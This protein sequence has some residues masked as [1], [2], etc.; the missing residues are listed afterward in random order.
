MQI[1]TKDGWKEFQKLGKV[2]TKCATNTHKR[3]RRK[4]PDMIVMT[5]EGTFHVR[6]A[7]RHAWFTTL[8]EARACL[9]RWEAE[10]IDEASINRLS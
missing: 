9:V 5:R 8:Q 3:R 7:G 10:V 2:V 6:I 4:G 1:M